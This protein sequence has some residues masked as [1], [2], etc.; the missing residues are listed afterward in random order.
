MVLLCTVLQELGIVLGPH[1]VTGFVEH[2]LHL[3]KY[4]HCSEYIQNILSQ[5]LP[6]FP[7]P[8]NIYL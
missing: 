7:S 5:E 8:P 4:F 1:K 6:Y 2:C 3:V